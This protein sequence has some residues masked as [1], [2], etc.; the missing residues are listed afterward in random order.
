MNVERLH[1][2]LI[3]LDSEIEENNLHGQLTNLHDH[4]QNQVNTPQDANHQKQLSKTRNDLSD[5]LEISAY[6]DYSPSWKQVID[7]IGGEGLF[8]VELKTRIDEIFARNQITAASA[9]EDIKK[10]VEDFNALRDSIKQTLSGLDGLQI[11]DEELEEG[12]CELGYTIPRAYVSNK[13]EGLEDEIHELNFIMNTLSEAVTGKKEDYKVKTISSSDFLLYVII[14]LQVADVLANATERILNVYKQ[15]LEIKVLRNDLKD[16]GVPA[17]QIKG[18]DTHANGLME[19][20]IKKIAKEVIDE[21]YNGDNG[22]KNEL[23]N[24]LTFAFNKLA[25]RIDSGFNV[26]IRVEALPEPEIEEGQE[27]TEKTEE[28][29]AREKKIRSIF[30][31]SKKIEYIKTE[32]KAILKLPEEKEK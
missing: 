8:G 15:I 26:E 3:D 6:N 16:K 21:H 18:I 30:E 20:E 29:T 7:E 24:G 1:R 14:G 11:G 28:E 31:S 25:N 22:R 23:Q 5:Y 19:K 12:E 2:I 27:P 4:L 32:G 10:I 13:L 17:N 9:L